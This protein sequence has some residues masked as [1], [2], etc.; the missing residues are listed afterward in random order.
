MPNFLTE[1]ITNAAACSIGSL[2][3]PT[4]M[5]SEAPNAVELSEGT[6]DASQP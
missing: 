2:L 1:S 6:T 4:R 3:E 5:L